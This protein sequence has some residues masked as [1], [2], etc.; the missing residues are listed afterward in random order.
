M[1]DLS[2]S[3][4]G[5]PSRVAM[6]YRFSFPYF[7]FELY[8]YIYTYLSRNPDAVIGDTYIRR[9]VP[10]VTSEVDIWAGRCSAT[11]H[12]LE[13]CAALAESS[14]GRKGIFRESGDK[15]SQAP[16]DIDELSRIY[17]CIRMV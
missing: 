2:C 14:A 7:Y 3:W 11:A 16:T 17:I 6:G 8:I 15:A 13:L 12:K 1:Y 4:V 10:V 9:L 5:W